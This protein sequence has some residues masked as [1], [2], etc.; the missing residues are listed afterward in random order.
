MES[1]PMHS[2]SQRMKLKNNVVIIITMVTIYFTV[3]TTFQFVWFFRSQQIQHQSCGNSE[4][5]TV[6][7]IEPMIYD[8]EKCFEVRQNHEK[9][10]E[11]FYHIHFNKTLHPD[12][13]SRE[14]RLVFNITVPAVL[15]W[16]ER[17]VVFSDVLVHL[18][19]SITSDITWVSKRVQIVYDDNS[20]HVIFHRCF[21]A[22]TVLSEI[23]QVD[24]SSA[25]KGA[26]VT[27]VVEQQ[28]YK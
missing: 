28:I 15:E 24:I 9:T 4:T 12:N 20:R 13:F 10:P 17:L 22:A 26:Y 21:N 2:G 8:S 27:L 23:I 6:S 14:L 5:S 3:S 18:I 19:G 7:R 16:N 1:T 25:L 11:R